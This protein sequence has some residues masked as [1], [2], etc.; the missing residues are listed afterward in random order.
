MHKLRINEFCKGAHVSRQDGARV[1]DAIEKNWDSG[2]PIELDFDGVNI[3]SVSFFD[4][5]IG[6]LALEHDSGEL[7]ARIRVTNISPA[8]RSLLNR[9]VSD[10]LRERA[11]NRTA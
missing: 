11:A 5:S 6:L 9:I 1:R 4:E 3:A 10:R 8:D 7:T 2:E